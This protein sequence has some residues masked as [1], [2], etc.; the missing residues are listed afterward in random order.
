MGNSVRRCKGEVDK[1]HERKG[2]SEIMKAPYYSAS[3]STQLTPDN[4]SIASCDIKDISLPEQVMT[5][6]CDDNKSNAMYHL[7]ISPRDS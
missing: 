4:V 5:T 6:E 1:S 7:L 2:K 3:A